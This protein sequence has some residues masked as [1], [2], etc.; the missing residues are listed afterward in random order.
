MPN[1]VYIAMQ[2]KAREPLYGRAAR[3]P[4]MGR[5]MSRPQPHIGAAP[6]RMAGGITTVRV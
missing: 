4:R 3:A 2:Q 1:P 5:K 6:L